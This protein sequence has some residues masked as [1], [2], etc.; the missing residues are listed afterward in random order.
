M[1]GFK[2]LKC[3]FCCSNM[4]SER[5]VILFPEDVLNIS[6]GL[7]IELNEFKN[8]YCNEEFIKLDKSKMTFLVLKSTNGKCVFLSI[9]NTCSIHNIKP[10]QC[11]NSPLEFL[12]DN[13]T[14]TP[15]LKEI[16][17]P[18]DWNTENSDEKIFRTLFN[19]L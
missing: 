8:R 10:Y 12:W 1:F 5:K 17:I 14:I 9:N 6:K 15:C 11:K 13:E 16:D 18:K 3:G 2:C 7:S 4:S 19:N